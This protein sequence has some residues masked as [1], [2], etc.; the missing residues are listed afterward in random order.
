MLI[1]VVRILYKLDFV[2][3]MRQDLTNQPLI[4]LGSNEGCILPKTSP[5]LSPQLRISELTADYLSVKKYGL[6]MLG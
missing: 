5:R 4:R 1:Y 3:Y 2:R 6:N